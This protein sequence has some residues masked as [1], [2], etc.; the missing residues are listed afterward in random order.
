[1]TTKEYL[2]LCWAR[3]QK[4]EIVGNAY[5]DHDLL[6]ELYA[7]S[8]VAAQLNEPD[9]SFDIVDFIGTKV[10]GLEPLQW[11][12]FDGFVSYWLTFD[13]PDTPQYMDWE[14]RQEEDKREAET[15]RQEENEDAAWPFGRPKGFTS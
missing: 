7:F 13:F 14:A 9:L 1:M 8:V 10:M 5:S 4:R 2:N 12:G 11:G 3:M 15:R 6:A